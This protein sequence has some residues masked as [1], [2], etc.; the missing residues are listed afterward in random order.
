MGEIRIRPDFRDDKDV[1]NFIDF[2]ILFEG[3]IES[4]KPSTQKNR[5]L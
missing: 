3:D 4:K 5:R 1:F 2:L